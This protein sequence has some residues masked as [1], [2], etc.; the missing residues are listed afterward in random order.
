MRR[1]AV[2]MRSLYADFDTDLS[3]LF[4]DE[5][6]RLTDHEISELTKRGL[7]FAEAPESH[8]SGHRDAHGELVEDQPAPGAAPDRCL[9]RLAAEQ[10]LQ[11][12]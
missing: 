4:P 8:R 3:E 10:R 1:R 2:L 7:W 12:R 6:D 9:S 11:R 5:V